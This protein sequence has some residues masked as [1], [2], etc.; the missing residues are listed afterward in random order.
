MPLSPRPIPPLPRLLGAAV[1]A[2][3]VAACG[4]DN[5]DNPADD[6]ATSSP[7]AQ[8]PTR[9]VESAPTTAPGDAERPQIM[10]GNTQPP[11]LVDGAGQAV[12]VLQL[13]PEGGRCD[14]E[15]EEAWPPVLATDTRPRPGDGVPPG[16]VASRAR[17]DGG[18]HVT[19]NG[20]PLYRYAAD[21]GA[22]RTAGDDVQDRWGHW[23][24][25]IVETGAPP[26]PTER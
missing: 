18:Q 9:D 11:H 15:C 13:N 8:R 3:V 14:A 25:V 17:P 23:E 1:I 10:L 5:A 21:R 20:M 4:G 12:Y 24:L 6:I 2:L 16:M 26:S 19:Y 7:D 22:G